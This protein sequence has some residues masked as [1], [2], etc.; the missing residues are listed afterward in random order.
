MCREVGA[1]TATPMQA[2]IP[3]AAATAHMQL[4]CT[5]RRPAWRCGVAHRLGCM[6][7]AGPSKTTT[8]ACRARSDDAESTTGAA[9]GIGIR[10]WRTE[11]NTIADAQAL[12]LA[13]QEA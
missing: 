4:Y 9:V 10:S 7:E 5:Q 13:C 6:G 3:N 2:A 1:C 11:S 12:Q 8:T